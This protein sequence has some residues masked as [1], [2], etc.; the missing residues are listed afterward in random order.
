MDHTTVRALTP[1]RRRS[2][3]LVAVVAAC[4]AGPLLLVSPGVTPD[5]AATT[6]VAA[7][8][9]GRELVLSLDGAVAGG[10]G[11]RVPTAGT[12]PTTAA[13]RT[14]ADAVATVLRHEGAG[15]ALRLPAFAPG[16]DRQTVPVALVAVTSTGSPDLDPGAS[17]FVLGAS[18]RLDATSTG[19]TVDNG[20]NVVQRGLYAAKS[21][22]K[23]Q[24][25]GRRPGCR[26]KGD[27]GAVAVYP[28][29]RVRADRWFDLSCRRSG[30]TVTLVQ[31]RVRA[32]GTIARRRWSRSGPIGSLSGLDATVPL[33]VGG[34]SNPSGAPL[35]ASA[36]Q[37]NGSVDDV[38]LDILD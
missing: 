24:F 10:D 12:S 31:Q 5:A 8:A 15:R 36:D 20:D 35:V 21:Q 16:A 2:A 11:T 17:D 29:T 13:V 33:T 37:L 28:D 38:Y 32:D 3:A 6:S 25:D 19:T 34:K 7:T 18:V 23:L 22:M 1:V 9:T 26:V 27:L 14:N 30:D 4:A